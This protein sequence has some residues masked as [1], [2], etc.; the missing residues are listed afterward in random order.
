ME[1]VAAEPLVI[2]ASRRTDI[3][4]FYGEWF[5]NR[6]RAGYVVAYNP[7]GGQRYEVSLRRE[8]VA[9]FVFWSKDFRPFLPALTH[10]ERLGYPFYFQFTITG[11]PRALEPNVPDWPRAAETARELAARY[12][13]EAVQWRFDPIILTDKITPQA[14][15][16][17]F[18]R[19]A[20]ALAGHTRRC[21]FSFVDLYAKV[22]RNM[23][24]YEADH[25]DPSR[26]PSAALRREL[27]EQLAG[28][29]QAR[30]MRLF[31]CCEPDLIGGDIRGARCV[32]GGLLRELFPGCG[33]SI[34]PRPSREGCGCTASRDLG[35]YDTCLH[36][37][38][39]CYANAHKDVALR[40][41]VDPEGESLSLQ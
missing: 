33:A 16:D 38:L 28:E 13:P 3:P 12:R 39:Y 22:Q 7:F 21:V 19:I 34:E 20:D 4:A 11:L 8:D 23:A 40:G 37:C 1:C 41:R 35:A 30:G 36:G 9:G 14:T 25:G 26:T 27:A 17:R 32:D 6:L 31:A 2:S 18:R 29:A 15:L 10:V 24:R 5:L